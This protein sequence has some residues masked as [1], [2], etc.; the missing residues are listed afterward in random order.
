M[1]RN[2]DRVKRAFQ[3]I[4]T[5]STRLGFDRKIAIAV[6]AR[7]WQI[8]SGTIIILLIARFLSPQQQGFYYTFNAVLALQ[9]F[10]EMGLSFVI[11]QVSS[12]EFVHL[13]WAQRGALLG[14]DTAV[15]RFASFVLQAVKWY[16]VAALII[17]AVMLPTG[18]LFFSYSKDITI[19]FAWEAPWI[20][21]VVAT[22]L[23][24]PAIPV[25]AAIEGSGRVTE[26]YR[27]RLIQGMTASISAWLVIAAGGGLYFAAISLFAGTLV[28]FVW[29]VLRNRGLL[30][31]LIKSRGT[32]ARQSTEPPP[33]AWRSE[34]WPMQ[35]RIGVSWMAGYFIT[36]LFTPILFYY[37]GAVP[38]GQMGMTL[39]VANILAGIAM[40]WLNVEAPVMGRLAATRSWRELDS[41]F[42]I[43]FWQS[44]ILLAAGCVITMIVVTALQG[45][46]FGQRF[47]LPLETALLLGSAVLTHIIGCLAQY[48]R[49]HRQEPFVWLSVIGAIMMA[50]AA[51]VLTKTYSTMGAVIATFSVNLLFGLPTGTLLWWVLRRQWHS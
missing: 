10:A 36:Q 19:D 1:T 32:H 27:L 51:W 12:H 16:L 40:T 26:V 11:L 46:S 39:A 9:V 44:T 25:L 31:L 33:F 6:S 30:E 42:A 37:H 47:L 41:L 29:L 24:F 23:S 17:M 35:W 3:S 45:L 8:L 49:A 7:A 5:V 14:S 18:L 50:I 15:S 2:A 13:S 43:R 48:L 34:V 20:L 21:L 28:A 38:A 4:L 22:A